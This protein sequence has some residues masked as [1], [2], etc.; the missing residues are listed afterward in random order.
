MFVFYSFIFVFYS[1]SF[2]PLYPPHKSV[3][4]DSR[5]MKNI[6]LPY[7]PDIM[8]LPTDLKPF[9]MVY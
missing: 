3:P 6:E 5:H 1:F 4:I 2:Y 7:T 8:I 9:A